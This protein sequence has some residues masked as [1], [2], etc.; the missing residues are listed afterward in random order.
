MSFDFWKKIIIWLPLLAGLA[1]V[2]GAGYFWLV[3]YE[4]NSVYGVINGASADLSRTWLWPGVLLGL[5]GLDVM[6]PEDF[7]WI[8]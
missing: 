8:D 3:Q 6:L 5:T 2:I 4:L 7:S 1:E